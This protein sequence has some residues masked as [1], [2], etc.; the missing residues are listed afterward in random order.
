MLYLILGIALA[1]VVAHICIIGG[2]R[3][4][5]KREQEEAERILREAEEKRKQEVRES[6]RRS[7][8]A[9]RDVIPFP[10]RAFVVCSNGHRYRLDDFEFNTGIKGDPLGDWYVYAVGCP[11]C[12]SRSWR[13]ED[14][15]FSKY[16]TCEKDCG[17]WFLSEKYSRCP[18]CFPIE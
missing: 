4:R 7:L 2:Q 9:S 18:L 17:Y 14:S 13:F 8:L 15:S 10:A 16:R 3:S 5:E 12:K 11:L 1:L 6:R